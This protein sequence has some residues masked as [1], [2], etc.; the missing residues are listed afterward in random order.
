MLYSGRHCAANWRRAQD[1]YQDMLDLLVN[2]WSN[3]CICLPSETEVCIRP[4]KCH[5]SAAYFNQDTSISKQNTLST[6]CGRSF[7]LSST[8]GKWMSVQHIMLYQFLSII[9]S[10]GETASEGLWEFFRSHRL[11]NWQTVLSMAVPIFETLV[12]G[13]SLLF[14]LL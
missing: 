12:H 14:C 1:P 6:R 9:Y 13:C 4:M 11:Q 7:F 10:K 3:I 8:L 2:F 5:P